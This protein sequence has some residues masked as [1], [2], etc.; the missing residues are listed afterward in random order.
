MKD[1]KFKN[2]ID[3]VK[4]RETLPEEEKV[5]VKEKTKNSKRVSGKSSNPDYQPLTVYVRRD[6]HKKVKKALVDSEQ[7]FSGLI[8]G[9]LN[10]WLDSNN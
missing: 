2:I 10:S 9:L 4:E 1:N 6:T 7:D 5:T 8:E 3:V